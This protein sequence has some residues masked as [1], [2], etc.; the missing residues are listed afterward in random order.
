MKPTQMLI[1]VEELVKSAR[2]QMIAYQA[3]EALEK[4]HTHTP[5]QAPKACF[6]GAV[7]VCP[8]THNTSTVAIW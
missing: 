3:S 7:G 1:L 2:D 8:I 6:W 5:N 4:D